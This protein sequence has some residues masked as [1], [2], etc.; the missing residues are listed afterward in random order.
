[1]I[2]VIIGDFTELSPTLHQLDVAAIGG[3]KKTAKLR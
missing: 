1:V 2:I 3:Q